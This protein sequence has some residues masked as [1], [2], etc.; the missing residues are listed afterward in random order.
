L[1][2]FNNDPYEQ[3][4]L[5]ISSG[6]NFPGTPAYVSS[7]LPAPGGVGHFHDLF[8]GASP[9]TASLSNDSFVFTASDANGTHGIYVL[10]DD[11]SITKVVSTSD[12]LEGKSI[13][14]L[15]LADANVLDQ[16]KLVFLVKF[17]D[18]S[19]AV[20][21]ADFPAVR[22]Y[23]V[24]VF[25]DLA[26]VERD[27]PVTVSTAEIH[28]V[29]FNDAN[30]NGR[31]DET[32][33]TIANRTVYIDT[34]GNDAQDSGEPM[35][36]TDAAGS[37][38]F[39]NLDPLE[40]YTIATVP[41]TGFVQTAPTTN[42]GTWVITLGPGQIVTSIN[43]G[44]AAITG[45]GGAGEGSKLSGQVQLSANGNGNL[46]PATATKL[47][48]GV[49][50]YLDLNND[51]QFEPLDAAGH[52]LEPGTPLAS[53][54]SYSFSGLTNS[55][56]QLRL[57]L[58][59][60]MAQISP[61]TGNTFTEKGT[62]I[63]VR[64]QEATAADFDQQ[65]GSDLAVTMSNSNEVWIFANSGT[66]TLTP[67]QQLAT[68][69]HPGNTAVADV[70]NDG[71]PDLIVSNAYGG[72]I[73]VFVNQKSALTPFLTTATLTYHTRVDP[74]DYGV[75]SGIT[76]GDFNGDGFA[77]LAVVNN[78]STSTS[79]SD[80]AI[81]INDT[82]T[83]PGVKFHLAS[84]VPV[85]IQPLS[86]VAGYFTGGVNLDLA[87]ANHGNGTGDSS[88]SVK[89]LQGN[90][91]GVFT[92]FSTIAVGSGP[93]SIA[94]ASLF[95]DKDAN[96]KPLPSLVTAN[97]G[98]NTVTILRGTGNG[99]FD[100]QDLTAGIGPS[101]VVLADV[102]ADGDLDIAVSNGSDARDKNHVVVLR[103][104]GG[105]VFAPSE[106]GGSATFYPDATFSLVAA[107]FDANAGVDLALVH[108]NLSSGAGYE[109]G[110]LDLL[111]NQLATDGVLRVA[112]E[113]PREVNNLTFGVALPYYNVLSPLDVTHDGHIAA[114][115]VVEIINYINA[116]GSGAF[117]NNKKPKY[118]Y[119]P[120][121]DCNIAADDVVTIINYI[122]A[123]PNR[124][125]EAEAPAPIYDGAAAS[126]SPNS[127]N[128]SSAAD[129]IALLALDIA[130]Q[131]KRRPT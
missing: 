53:D 38:F 19:Q 75:P 99:Q 6:L 7:Q 80:V 91:A 100:R 96:Q 8:N 84:V 9:S 120:N 28:G 47:L 4:D 64:P 105:G 46:A 116:S 42:N 88:S 104:Q 68:G 43:F 112:L 87:I 59:A 41:V 21:E 95:G 101:S 102:D 57:K 129:L 71:W 51:G 117:S 35:T 17:G 108:P 97:Y 65:H 14:G 12:K 115:D 74:K 45:G 66:G 90:G 56:V 107:N 36:T 130:S 92:A 61:L 81:L 33:P 113:T 15:E 52:P 118:Y 72:T 23:R 111:T 125:A 110:K 39:D 62:D 31:K 78:Y 27:F 77:D 124:D 20:Y 86:I 37:Y 26:D 109:T 49:M 121:N 22:G 2:N 1:G 69:D 48:D 94:A 10:E 103:N 70:N 122:N 73:S 18:G 29:V 127:G 98:A 85:G 82:K 89:L 128:P 54:G 123:H 3:I 63:P 58:P 32:E 83:G 11:R 79:G 106:S 44:S 60:K 131:P 119:D 5:A 40:T 114:D 16:N 50:V 24:L 13:L 76:S 93:A 126:D 55:N 67:I 25:D 30:R 34:N